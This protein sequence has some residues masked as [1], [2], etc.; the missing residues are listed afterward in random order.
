MP[1]QVLIKKAISLMAVLPAMETS[2]LGSSERALARRI[3]RTI[4]M[5]NQANAAMG[6]KTR[7]LPS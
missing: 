5:M 3:N 2:S 7:Y 1:G 4:R 6:N